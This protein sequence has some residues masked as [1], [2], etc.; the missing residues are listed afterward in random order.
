MSYTI[1]TGCFEKGTQ[2][3]KEAVI[4][5]FGSGDVQYH[6]DFFFHWYNIAHEYGHCLCSH[7]GSKIL[8]LQQEFLVNDFAVAVW[9]YGGFRKELEQ[10]QS[11]TADI[12]RRIEN[13]V[14]THMSFHDYYGQ[15]WQTEQIMDVSTYGYFQ[16]KSVQKALENRPPLSDILP[17]MGIFQEVKG[18]L[19]SVEKYPVSAASSK[20]V[21]QSLRQL[22]CSLEIEQPDVELELVEDPSV[23]CVRFVF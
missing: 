2:E 9:G 10:L 14:P 4:R 8:G 17:K 7:Y 12:L 3:Q 18:S 6:F 23:H 13:P 5:L 11:L 16:F 19:F 15:I 20:N 22:L 21:L 1:Q